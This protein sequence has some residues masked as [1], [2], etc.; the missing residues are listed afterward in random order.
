MKVQL[1][2]QETIQT[3]RKSLEQSSEVSANWVN[4]TNAHAHNAK[5]AHDILLKVCTLTFIFDSQLK[6]LFVFSCIAELAFPL[7]S[8]L[9]F[10][11][12]EVEKVFKQCKH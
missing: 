2:Q 7:S 8:F 3:G 10:S 9:C 5:Y 4:S 1:T 6:W 11:F 12:T